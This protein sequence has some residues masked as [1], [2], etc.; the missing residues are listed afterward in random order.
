MGLRLTKFAYKKGKMGNEIETNLTFIP[1]RDFHTDK[2]SSYWLPKD[3]EEQMRL[4]GVSH[5]RNKPVY[6]F[7]LLSNTLP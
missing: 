7:F 3:E 5:L 2:N 1:E 6:L 4:T